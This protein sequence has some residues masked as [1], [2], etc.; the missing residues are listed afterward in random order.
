[1]TP[2]MKDLEKELLKAVSDAHAARAQFGWATNKTDKKVS[3][4]KSLVEIIIENEHK[5]DS[6]TSNEVLERIETLDAKEKVI[7]FD[8]AKKISLYFEKNP[9]TLI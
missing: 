9:E 8:F 4:L 6:L 7:L 5:K 2:T 1:M 3:Y